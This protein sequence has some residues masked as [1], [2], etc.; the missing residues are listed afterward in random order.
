MDFPLDQ[1]KISLSGVG[2]VSVSVSLSHTSSSS[3]SSPSSNQN[4]QKENSGLLF[5]LKNKYTQFLFLKKPIYFWP[6]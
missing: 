4:V 3:S 1:G 2:F 5:G 6:C